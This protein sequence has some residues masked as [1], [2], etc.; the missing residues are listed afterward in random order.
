MNY[1]KIIQNTLQSRQD[2]SLSTFAFVAGLAAGAAIA[3]LFAPKPGREFRKLLAEKLR[4][5]Q[6][7][8]QH[9]LEEHLFDD[10][11]EAARE[12][13]V[14]L[15]GPESKR[16]DPTQIK[17]PSAGTTAWKAKSPAE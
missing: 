6:Q 2:H 3:V 13:A 17:I 8:P 12:H 14:Q 7:D 11:R 1:R 9:E 15:Q 16:K 10:L 4:F 5:G